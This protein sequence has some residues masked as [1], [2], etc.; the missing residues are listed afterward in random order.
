MK[1]RNLTRA[2]LLASVTAVAVGGLF[3]Q[4]AAAQGRSVPTFE[5]DKAWPKLPANMKI[6]D[7]SSFS[8]DAQD[9]IYL[10][11]RPRTLKGDDLK[12]A[13]KPIVVFD[14]SGNYL[15]AWGG[16]GNGYDWPQREHGVT[17]DYK[18]NVW[19]GGNNCPEANLANLKPVA[20]D[21]YLKFA[22][23]GKFLLQIGKANASKGDN[24]TAN[25]H[26]PS[27]AQ[28]LQSTNEVFISDGY[29][30]HR[31]IVY[32]ADTG[33][34]KR[35]W[36]AFGKPPAGKTSCA[37]VGPKEWP[38][39]DGPADFNVAHAIKVSKDGTVYLADRENRRV[40][41]FDKDGKYMNQIYVRDQPFARNLALSADPEQQ[42]LY[43]G[44]AK[45]IAIIDR[46]SFTV[47]GQ[48]EPAGIVGP[49]HHIATDSKGNI[50]IAATG[51]GMQKLTYKGMSTASR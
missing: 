10:I 17:I 36:G 40:Q 2:V 42:F 3:V 50:Y 41:R 38:A 46:K 13:A 43:T 16:E 20:D 4:P 32:D 31:V 1:R 27:D 26:R 9:N 14:S 25:M 5:V 34:F 18:G 7:A 45:G 37:I 24:D 47:V 15:R 23:D 48:I 28:V 30:N 19:L 21:T 22:P 51:M 6:G 12:N 35:M 49:G 8:A 11:H 29:G 44:H 33:A 39:G